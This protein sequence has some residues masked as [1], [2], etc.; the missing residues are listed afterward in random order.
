MPAVLL[1]GKSTAVGLIFRNPKATL[2]LAEGLLIAVKGAR[3]QGHG[4]APH[5]GASQPAMVQSSTK[6]F[7]RG[8][9]V[10]RV[11]DLASC[12]DV[13]INGASTVFAG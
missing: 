4:K 8:V 6:V 3:V 11:G 13:G 5:S 1:I 10:C 9:G 7:A 2:T 12:G